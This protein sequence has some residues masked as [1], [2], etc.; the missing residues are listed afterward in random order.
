[1][2]YCPSCVLAAIIR[3][4]WPP[5][6]T[7]NEETWSSLDIKFYLTNEF[8][9]FC[10]P[11]CFAR[12]T[13][14]M[15]H[16]YHYWWSSRWGHTNE[17][18]FRHLG[19]NDTCTWYKSYSNHIFDSAM[20]KSSLRWSKRTLEWSNSESER[21]SYASGKITDTALSGR[22]AWHRPT[23]LASCRIKNTD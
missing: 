12:N 4:F 16:K 14:K 18:S 5:T 15:V 7:I 19:T 22:S 11:P 23:G 8:H 1:M 13:G 9:E 20:F 3:P 21:K 17:G 2:P 10:V 6:I